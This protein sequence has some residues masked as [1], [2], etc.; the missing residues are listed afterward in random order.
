MVTTK[1]PPYM[2]HETPMNCK[3]VHSN[4]FVPPYRFVEEYVKKNLKMK[5]YIELELGTV[6]SNVQKFVLHGHNKDS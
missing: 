3:A 6:N 1:N 2:E 5:F 4:V